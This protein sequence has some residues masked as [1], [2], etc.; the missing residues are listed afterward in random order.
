M[1]SHKFSP[2]LATEMCL[3]GQVLGPVNPRGREADAVALT[4]A[5]SH[6]SLALSLEIKYYHFS[7]VLN[8]WRSEKLRYSSL[9]IPHRTYLIFNPAI[10]ML[11]E[12]N[13]S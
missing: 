4:L 7:F 2:L 8:Y 9:F 13:Y 11:A 5:S 6:K 1:R 3:G 10:V 12:C